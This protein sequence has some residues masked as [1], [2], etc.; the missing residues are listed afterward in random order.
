[1]LTKN[2]SNTRAKGHHS[3]CTPDK[4]SPCVAR[5][6][7]RMQLHTWRATAHDDPTKKHTQRRRRARFRTLRVSTL[8]NNELHNEIS[9]AWKTKK[10]KS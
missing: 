7:K 1:M 10:T 9:S 8:E 5:I 3:R 6:S 4:P 2:N